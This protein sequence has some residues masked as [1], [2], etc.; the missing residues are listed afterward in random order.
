[1][2]QRLK[3]QKDNNTYPAAAA[4]PETNYE[5]SEF[6]KLRN[7]NI[8]RNNDMLRKVGIEPVT[9]VSAVNRSDVKDQRSHPRKVKEASSSSSDDGSCYDDDCDDVNQ[10]DASNPEER[11]LPTCMTPAPIIKAEKSSVPTK[12]DNFKAN[13]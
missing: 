5:P 1:M 9:E 2:N 3:F 4:P 6:E 13:S 7:E 11:K 10:R 12:N 8:N